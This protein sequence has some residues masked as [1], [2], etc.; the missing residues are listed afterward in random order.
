MPLGFAAYGAEFLTAEEVNQIGFRYVIGAVTDEMGHTVFAA[1]FVYGG[2][3]VA[4]E[5]HDF[6]G[7]HHIGAA[8]KQ[9]CIVAVE[10]VQSFRGQISRHTGALAGPCP[11]PA[12]GSGIVFRI[13]ST[14]VE[15]F[16]HI[17]FSDLI[18][19]CPFARIPAGDLAALQ[20]IAGSSFTDMANLIE[21]F[22]CDNVGNVL[23]IN[24]FI[25]GQTPRFYISVGS[26]DRRCMYCHIRK[27]LSFS[28]FF[29]SK[30]KNILRDFF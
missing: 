3:A 2:F 11:V 30:R 1:P 21:L 4:G 26:A 24:P 27:F 10:P 14:I 18:A 19:A 12:W 13:H 23:P 28:L 16:L 15:I 6:T 25:H 7:G 20:K 17:F 5:R 22:F 29:L 9:R 8:D